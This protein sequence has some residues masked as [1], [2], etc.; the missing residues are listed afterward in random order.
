[1]QV[2][3]ISDYGGPE[4]LKLTNREI[5]VPEYGQVLIKN[6]YVGV[7]RPDCLQR[8]GLYHPPK[9]ASDIL[10]LESAGT[11][12][13]IGGGVAGLAIGDPVCAL[14]PGGGYAE[15]S[16]TNA[17]HVLPVPKGMNMQMAAAIPE[18][19]FTVWFNVF[20]N[21][22]LTAGETLLVHGGTS[23]IGT[24]VIQ[25]A[26]LFGAKVITTAGTD[27]KC[28]EC[29]KLGAD[30]V[31]NYQ[32]QDFVDA[33]LTATNNRGADVVFDMVG[34]DYTAR[35]LKAL[36]L[37]GRLVNIAFLRG[38][39]AEINLIDIMAKGLT[40]TGSFLRPQSDLTKQ[41]IASGLR[42]N[43]WPHFDNQRIA[44]VMDQIF[45]LKDAVL[46]HTRMEAGDHIGKIAL[47]V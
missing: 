33:V 24:T 18:T 8:S 17:T 1:M 30:I 31:I 45:D 7:N 39:K 16:L 4:V 20:M 6:Q 15:Y 19:F 21:A 46:A 32:Q 35:N 11:I 25:L 28:T 13:A 9:S 34:G 40:I 41:I 10:G 22:N 2:I 12:A 14:L 38:I 23:S 37:A 42:K 36:A 47:K 29:K 5:P 43:V 26:K 27:D 3:E 44:P